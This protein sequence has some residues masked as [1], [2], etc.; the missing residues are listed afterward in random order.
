MKKLV[1]E[2]L[3]DYIKH[4]ANKKKM[5]HSADFD[6]EVNR[7]ELGLCPLCGA[8]IRLEDFKDESSRKEFKISGL[9]QKCQDE[10][11]GNDK[12]ND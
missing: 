2:N 8:P 1:I 3:N 6:K 9:C 7:A 4:N 12:N 5:L 11:F 10:I